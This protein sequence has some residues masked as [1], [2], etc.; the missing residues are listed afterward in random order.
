[1]ATPNASRLV[2]RGMLTL[3]AAY[4]I[5]RFLDLR[6]TACIFQGFFAVFAVMIVVIF[7]E[8]LGQMIERVAVW[9]FSRQP[10]A[11]PTATIADILPRVLGE[12]AR[13]H[14]GALVVLAGKDPL[15]RGEPREGPSKRYGS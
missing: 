10:I 11:P 6:M 14:V 2:V 7:Q 13:V 5:V 1:M 4:L 12:L 9:R 3:G 8:E 15:D